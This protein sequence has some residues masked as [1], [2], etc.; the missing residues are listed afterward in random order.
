VDLNRGWHADSYRGVSRLSAYGT[1]DGRRAAIV[2]I[3]ERRAT[4]I[5]LTN[6]DSANAKGIADEITSRLLTATMR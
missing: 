4:I 1:P 6:D 2:R 3:P 5:V